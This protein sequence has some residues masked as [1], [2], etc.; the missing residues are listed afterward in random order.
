MRLLWCWIWVVMALASS[1]LAQVSP[2]GAV[3]VVSGTACQVSGFALDP[4]VPGSPVTVQIYINGPLGTGSLLASVPANQTRTDLPVT[5]QT[6]AF[7]YI[8]TG[9]QLGDGKD[10]L[11]Y[12]YAQDLTGDPT[13]L[14]TPQGKLI[15]CGFTATN[16][17]DY[18][19]KADGVTDDSGA[20]QA[21]I[22]RTVPGGTVTIP[23]GTYLL[24]GIH[25]FGSPVSLPGAC[26]GN[27]GSV[28]SALVVSKPGLTL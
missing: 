3:D 19:A 4:D 21:A 24:A 14:L 22:D 7:N 2:Q 26:A 12:V 9:A 25:G 28:G 10:H 16:V 6:H 15:N 13:A 18:G 11:L 27:G 20:L 17:L 23:D 8:G 5:Q 1:A